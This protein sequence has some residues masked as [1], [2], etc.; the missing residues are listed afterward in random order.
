MK[1]IFRQYGQLKSKER[2]QKRKIRKG[3]SQRREENSKS[4]KTIEEK[5]QLRAKFRKVAK[6]CVFPLFCGFG[7]SKSR[8]A[9]AAGAEQAGQTT[10]A[11]LHAVV[12]RSIFP[13]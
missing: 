13:S 3:K 4:K 11:K 6:R 5:M 1:S 8:L 9:K 2:S 7:A 10:N 12:A